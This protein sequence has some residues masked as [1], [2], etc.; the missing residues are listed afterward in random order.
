MY[1]NEPEPTLGLNPA[2]G[3]FHQY[4]GVTNDC[5]PTAAAIL[6]NA[7]LDDI[8]Y[9]GSEVAE[10]MNRGMFP[11]FDLQAFI[12]AR[13]PGWATFPWGITRFL[14]SQQ[15]PASWK[16][17][18]HR[19]TLMQAVQDGRLTAV[20]IGQPFLCRGWRWEGWSHYLIL[21]GYQQVHGWLLLDPAV[22]KQ[23]GGKWWQQK[24][25]IWKKDEEFLPLWDN[26]LR[27]TITVG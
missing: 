1:M 23:P 13:I 21:V 27:M 2:L 19:G 15:I 17:F 22:K 20:V 25:M 10:R 14:R 7:Y 26:M 5:G 4:Q 12:P 11:G 9:Q 18:G 3:D 6:G 24:G 16:I 8:R